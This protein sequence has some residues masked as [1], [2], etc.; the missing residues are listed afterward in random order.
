MT[1]TTV[2]YGDVSPQTVGG[3]W[4][5][6]FFLPFSV[7]FVS[8]NLSEL[9]GILLNKAEDGKLQALLKVDLSLEALL[10]MD[11][12]GDGEITEYE[13]IKF[14]LTTAGM[15]DE[16]TLDSLHSR[17]QV[18][19]L[20]TRS[21]LSINLCT[22]LREVRI[23][24][25]GWSMRIARTSHLFARVVFYFYFLNWLLGSLALW[26]SVLRLAFRLF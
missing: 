20:H 14:M 25:C 4:A 5:C 6:F 1:G 18:R 24:G 12:D 26:E 13:F 23:R 19:V 10:S 17:F 21:L 9:A 15:A 7:I 22:G 16:D 3:R 8:T 2:G 11:Q